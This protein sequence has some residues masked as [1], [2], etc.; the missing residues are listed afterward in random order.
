MW[1]TTSG[2]RRCR[3]KYF[4]EVMQSSGE[5]SKRAPTGAKVRAALVVLAV[6]AGVTG[7]VATVEWSGIPGQSREDGA[8]YRLMQMPVH[9]VLGLRPPKE[10]TPLLSQLIKEQPAPELYALRAKQ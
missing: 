7:A 9:S 2:L 3:L 10:S 1:R 5:S 4:R 8:L 6:V